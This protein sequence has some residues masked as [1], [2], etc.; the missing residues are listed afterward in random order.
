MLE[1]SVMKFLKRVMLLVFLIALFSPLQSIAGSYSHQQAYLGQHFYVDVGSDAYYLDLPDFKIATHDK[2]QFTR[3]SLFTFHN[4]EAAY[5]PKITIGYHFH[6][7]ILPEFFSNTANVY[8]TAMGF[9]GHNTDNHNGALGNGVDWFIDGSGQINAM[10]PN[11]PT[12]LQNLH[13]STDYRYRNIG[14]FFAGASK[15]SDSRLTVRPL[16]GAV[17]S[18]LDQDYKYS[19]QH[20]D[21]AG[22]F[23]TNSV[24]ED[25]KGCYYGAELGSNFDYQLSQHFILTGMIAGQAL[26]A[27]ADFNG[28]QVG[29][30][31]P[32][33]VV[34][35]AAIKNV[36]NSI[37]Q[38]TYRAIAKVGVNYNITDK[39]DSPTVGVNVGVDQW[40]GMPEIVNPR[41][42][43]N[44]RPAHVEF[45]NATN[46]FAGITVHIPIG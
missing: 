27:Q 43:T 38:F 11:P 7:F 24:K 4:H 17:Y 2:T 36:N 12:S 20:G 15:K 39:P 26:H 42:T 45:T 21:G 44:A 3:S 22:G 31:T 1:A 9:N 6:N 18:S 25:V 8:V 34:P 33:G 40:G 13:Y 46:Y 10:G 16:V 14:V 19:L 28:H 30:I 37:S 32:T 5:M 29:I 23:D 41:G 35:T